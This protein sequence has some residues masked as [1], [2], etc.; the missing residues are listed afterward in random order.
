MLTAGFHAASWRN[1]SRLPFFRL[2]LLVLAGCTLLS[3]PVYAQEIHTGADL[4]RAMHARYVGNWYETLTFAQ[5]STTHAPYGTSKT[6]IWYEAA[7]LPGKLRIDFVKPSD[8]NGLVFSDGNLYSYKAG[9]LAA[10]RPFVHLLLVLGFD[11]YRQDPKIT[12][13]QVAAQGFDFSKVH[14][15]SWQGKTVYVVGADAGDQKTK[16]FWIEKERLLFVRLLGPDDKDKTKISD[17]RFTDYRKL[18][19]GYVAAGVEFYLDNK[20]IFDETYFDIVANPKLDPAV[21]DPKQ[22]ATQHWEK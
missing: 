20:L 10:T 22:Y 8:G 14:E 13:E 4:L 15:E 11:V 18:S 17:K 19:I 1:M 3:M 7:L 12:I 2:A 21:F 9:Q 5:N 16:Q 6:D